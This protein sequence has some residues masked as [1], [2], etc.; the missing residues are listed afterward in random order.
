[1]ITKSDFE[2]LLLKSESSTLDFKRDQYNFANDK[3]KSKTAKFIKD[4]ISFCNTIRTETAYIIIGVEVS[5]DGSKNLIGLNENVDD[6]VFQDKIKNKVTPNPVFSYFTFQYLDKSYGILEI[7][8]KKYSEPLSPTLKM[9]GLEP[10][11]IYFRRGSTNSEATGREVITINKWLESLPDEIKEG[12]LSDE[13]HQLV[14]RITSRIYPLSECIAQG[15][16]LAERNNLEGL[17]EFCKNELTGWSN[18]VTE[19]EIPKLLSYRV[20]EVL[21][22]PYEIEVNPYAGVNSV[23]LLNELRKIKGVFTQRILFPQPIS[24]IEKFIKRISENPNSTILTLK[25]SVGKFFSDKDLGI[26]NV[27]LYANRDNLDNIYNGIRQSLIDRLL[28]IS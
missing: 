19:E 1:M 5:D 6:S 26:K 8:I 24:E 28:E 20:N 22:S 14:S 13:V 27:T 4:I 9:K 23:G 2:V 16:H 10:G 7:P 17:K 25:M 11:E 21:I 3:D 18:K 12:S 15:L